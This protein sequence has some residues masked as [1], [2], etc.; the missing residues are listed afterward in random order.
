MNNYDQSAKASPLSNA[1]ACNPQQ[2]LN[3]KV[4]EMFDEVCYLRNQA[5]TIR[6][7]LFGQMP[8]CPEE[9]RNPC[10]IEDVLADMHNVIRDAGKILSIINERT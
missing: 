10:C 8:Q 3:S 5:E 6:G 2:P 9:K 1:V 7:K 4:V